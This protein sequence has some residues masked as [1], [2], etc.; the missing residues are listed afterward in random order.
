MKY[1]HQNRG[2]SEQGDVN[3]CYIPQDVVYA[4]VFLPST[5]YHGRTGLNMKANANDFWHMLTFA[6]IQPSLFLF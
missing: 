1:M 4:A 3:L 2:Y 5:A 6:E